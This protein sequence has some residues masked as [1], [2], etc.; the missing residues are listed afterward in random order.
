MCSLQG[1]RALFLESHKNSFSWI[2][3]WYGMTKQNLR[4]LELQS[5]STVNAVSSLCTI[6][7]MII[8]RIKPNVT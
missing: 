6:N 1:E 4:E 2:D 8:F 5:D 3:E 7:D